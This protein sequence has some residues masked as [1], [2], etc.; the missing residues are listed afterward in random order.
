NMHRAKFWLGEFLVSG[1][2]DG[3]LPSATPPR[4]LE[5]VTAQGARTRRH[6][7]VRDLQRFIVPVLTAIAVQSLLYMVVTTRPGRDDWQNIWL[8]IV[9]MAF[10][11]ALAGFVLTAFRRHESS[12][13]S[14]ALV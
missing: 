4:A 12:I 5:Y 10:V 9:A 1:G 3:D 7:Y 2:N 13:I 14:S 11:P 6:K 8:A